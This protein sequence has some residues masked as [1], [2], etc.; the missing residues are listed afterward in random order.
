M[1]RFFTGDPDNEA[2]KYQQGGQVYSFEWNPAEIDWA[3]TAGTTENKNFVLKTEEAVFREVPDYVQ[4]LPDIGGNI[5]VR[6]NLWNMLG[7]KQPAGF[8]SDDIVEVVF[9]SFS[10]TPSGLTHL[11]VGSVCSKHCH[12]EIGVSEC[13]SNVCTPIAP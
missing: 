5:E 4:C 10:F 6:L 11:P 13:I 3:T 1:H 12:C 7:N 8:N 2:A 9:D